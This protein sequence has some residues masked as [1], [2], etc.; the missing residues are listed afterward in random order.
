MFVAVLGGYR[1]YPFQGNPYDLSIL[2]SKTVTFIKR[3]LS[4]VNPTFGSSFQAVERLDFAILDVRK[5]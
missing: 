4:S 5:E 3:P 1:N 2:L